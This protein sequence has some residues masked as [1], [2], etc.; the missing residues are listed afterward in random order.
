MS[1]YYR[2]H[3]NAKLENAN[4]EIFTKNLEAA[5][6]QSRTVT[7]TCYIIPV[8][9]HVYGAVQSG[10][11][12]TDAKIIDALSKLNQDFKAQNADY[13]TVHNTF[14]GVRSS[15]P[16][17]LFALAQ[18]DPAGAVTSGIVYHPT[19]AGFA[20][21]AGYDAA[22]AAHAWNNYKYMNVY[23]MNDIMDRESDKFHPKKKYRPIAS[24][25]ISLPLARTL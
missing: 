9:F 4:F 25:R 12:V 20:N 10:K 13:A 16:N 23:I 3:P 5:T 7:T 11:T 1:D 24:G 14:L 15:M 2:S 21:G 22:I 8:V 18:K 17:V 19:A 6:N